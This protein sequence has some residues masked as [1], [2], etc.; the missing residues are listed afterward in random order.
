MQPRPQPS[1]FQSLSRRDKF[2]FVLVIA[3]YLL[4]PALII[5]RL[6]FGPLFPNL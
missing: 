6:L 5:Y 3:V 4:L 1:V 2:L